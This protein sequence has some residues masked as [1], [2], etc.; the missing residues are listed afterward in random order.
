MHRHHL[1]ALY[2]ELLPTNPLRRK[3]SIHIVSPSSPPV[4]GTRARSPA[5][6]T[7]I[8]DMDAWKSQQF[9][10]PTESSSPLSD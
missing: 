9:H 7:Y 5:P 8:P 2:A 1:E 3:L 6:P 10:R 4:P